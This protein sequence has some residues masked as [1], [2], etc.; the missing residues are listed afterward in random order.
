MS[1]TEI[2]ISTIII[3]IKISAIQ[4]E[5][6]VFQKQISVLIESTD[7]Y[8]CDRDICIEM[9]RSLVMNLIVFNVYFHQIINISLLKVFG[10]FDIYQA[11][12]FPDFH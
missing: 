11:S 9:K 2:K 1:L 6:S 7:I 12:E 5:I 3:W 4:V 10:M 8:N